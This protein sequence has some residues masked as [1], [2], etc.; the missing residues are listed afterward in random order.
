MKR[1]IIPSFH[2]FLV[3]LENKILIFH[4]LNVSYKD[5]KSTLIA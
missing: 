1:D 4:I 3:H 5:V 2:I